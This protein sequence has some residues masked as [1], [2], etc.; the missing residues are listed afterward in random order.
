MSRHYR[1]SFLQLP[2]VALVA[3]VPFTAIALQNSDPNSGGTPVPTTPP[4]ICSI[5]KQTPEPC[6]GTTR[7][8]RYPLGFCPPAHPIGEPPVDVCQPQPTPPAAAMM[9]SYLARGFV[10]EGSPQAIPPAQP[11][12]YSWVASGMLRVDSANGT[13]VDVSCRRAIGG[14]Y[15][16]L[17]VVTA[18]GVSASVTDYLSCLD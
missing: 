2:L 12:T 11:L 17:T 6:P 10:C 16:T 4:P 14:G 18:Q 3:L 15:L 7:T 13:F 8:D 5:G 9:C 1:D